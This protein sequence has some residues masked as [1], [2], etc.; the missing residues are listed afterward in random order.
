MAKATSLQA[1]FSGGE[2]SP[3]AMG[4]SDLAKWSSSVKII[5]N[6]LINQL[7]GGLYRPGTRY[8]ASTKDNGVAR[9]MPFQY[10]SDQDY[11]MEIGDAYMRMYSN[12]ADLLTVTKYVSVYPTAQTADYVKAT[13]EYSAEFHP[14]YATDPTKNLTGAWDG[15]IWY[16]A[17]GNAVNQRFHIDL[18]SAKVATRIYYEN[19]HESGLHTKYGVKTFTIWGSNTAGA[20]ADLTYATDTNWTQITAAQTTFDRHSDVDAVDPKYIEITN[21][22]A[23]RYYAFKFADGWGGATIGVR[24]LVLQTTLSSTEVTS[25][26]LEAD[27]FEVQQA[28][29][30][31]VKYLTHADYDTQKLSRT[32]AAA[33]SLDNVTFV[34]GPFMDDNITGTTITPSAATGNGITLTA[35]TA[36]FDATHVDSLWKVNEAVVKITA[37]TSTKI[38]TGNVQ[39]E[40]DGT[41]GNINGVDAHTSWAEGEF[42]DYSGWPVGCCFH[43]GR[44]WYGKDQKIFGSNKYAY[45]NFDKGS[46]GDEEAVIFEIATEERTVIQWLMSGRKAL[47]I[48]TTGGTFSA[49]GTSSV[50][51]TPGDIQIAR[52]TNYGVA[53][54][55]P[56]RISSFSYYV[57]RTLNSIRELSYSYDIDSQVARDMNLLADH[58]LRDGDGVVD[59]DTQQSPNDRLWCVRD[60]GQLSVLTRNAEQEIMGWCRIVAGADSQGDGEFESVTVIPKQDANDQIWVVTKRVI[61]GTT[62]RFIEF[63]TA[64]DFDEDWDAVRV[65]S[66]VTMDSPITITGATSADPVVVTAVAH[67][68]SN[69]DQIKINGIVGMT[70]LNGNTYLISSKTD[71][72]FE[73][74][75]TDSEDIDGSDY[76]TYISGGEARLMTTAITGLLHLE[77][78]AVT[79]QA[80][81]VALDDT[82]TVASGAIT[83]DSKAAVT[84]SGL[85]YEGT[86]QLLK[87][88][89]GNPTGTGQGQNR[90]IYLSTIRVNRS[91]GMKIGK[92]EDTLDEVFF[93]ATNATTVTDLFTGDLEKFFMTWWDKED[94]IIIRQDVS[95]PLNILCIITKSEVA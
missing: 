88:S 90:R 29:K 68:L 24:R 65:D 10:S 56:K 60:D 82:F 83:L 20:F 94:E 9:L 87:L 35:S 81:G 59:L 19:N 30:N 11:V 27:V 53:L 63:F 8:I 91:L 28:H 80:D 58:I 86:I 34:R 93:G 23:Y 40:P 22:I 17:N 41:G 39:V 42:S 32:G 79:V 89:D 25:P 84:H 18:G 44:L 74:Q 77:G 6:F 21:T 38:V 36:I 57:Q 47:S 76:T 71:D 61:D 51:I 66:S 1:N 7:G 13:T 95:N 3:L 46:A 2:V 70:E 72:T 43:D 45:D 49:S 62:K 14:Y 15:H 4:R 33:F 54:L 85:P 16:A 50:S 5:E 31:D 37:Y 78:E 26:Y 73:L 52:D 48:G 67:G 12:E 75:D 69:G 64:E 92:T 55:A